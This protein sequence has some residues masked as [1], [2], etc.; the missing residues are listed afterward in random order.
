MNLKATFSFDGNLITQIA[1]S[2]RS[3]DEAI[4]ELIAKCWDA[5]AEEL[6]IRIPQT[7]KEDIIIIEDNGNG[8][9]PKEVQSDFLNIG[10]NRKTRRGEF[11]PK[12]R[13]R[14]K[15][16]R[17]IGKFAALLMLMKMIQ[18]QPNSQLIREKTKKKPPSGFLVWI[19]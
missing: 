3:T 5:E 14:I 6:Y 7:A 4:K 8:M 10:Y 2:Y 18:I 16:E 19:K 1:R 9:T 11:T 12:K 15:G 17:G 13:R